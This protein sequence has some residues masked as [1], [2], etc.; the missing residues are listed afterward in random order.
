[1]PRDFSAFRGKT[2]GSAQARPLPS[3]AGWCTA[4]N[5]PD[6]VRDYSRSAAFSSPNFSMR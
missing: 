3:I 6:D 1:M 5:F 2:N 4:G